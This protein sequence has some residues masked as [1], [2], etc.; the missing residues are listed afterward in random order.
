VAITMKTTVGGQ[1]TYN[2]VGTGQAGSGCWTEVEGTFT[3]SAA[4]EKVVMY[5]EGAPVGTDV[6]VQTAA[7]FPT[8]VAS[9]PAATSAPSGTAPSNLVSDPLCVSF[10]YKVDA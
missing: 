6:Y 2:R 5:L 4:A 3:L 1:D 10:T 9:T 7:L 8:A